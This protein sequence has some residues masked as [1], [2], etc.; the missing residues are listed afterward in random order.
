M[1]HLQG[2]GSQVTDRKAAPALSQM[3]QPQKHM[4]H[5]IQAD[6]YHFLLS[7]Y[8]VDKPCN[9]APIHVMPE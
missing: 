3:R 9:A 1:S 7:S 2:I 8:L 6:A 5:D 4:R